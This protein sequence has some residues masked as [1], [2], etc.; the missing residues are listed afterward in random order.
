MTRV[1]LPPEVVQQVK[2]WE[3][4]Q[5]YNP[6]ET[7]RVEGNLRLTKTRR[8]VPDATHQWPHNGRE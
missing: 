6:D 5:R 4:R 7:E 1:S 2:E 3:F 8:P